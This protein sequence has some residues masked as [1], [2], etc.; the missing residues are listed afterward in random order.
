MWRPQVGAPMLNDPAVLL[1]LNY[2]RKRKL[3]QPVVV[4]L[5]L[6][7]LMFVLH[8]GFSML[9]VVLLGLAAVSVTAFVQFR[10]RV[11]WW[12][13][14]A[15]SVLDGAPPVRVRSQVVGGAGAWTLLSV[16]GGR[17][18]LRVTNTERAV[19][20]FAAR[21]REVSLIGPNADG[22]AAVM[23][24]SLPVPLPAKVVPAPPNPQPV[25]VTD[26]DLSRWAAANTA[27]A[28]YLGLAVVGLC[29]ASVVFDLLL[30]IDGWLPATIGFVFVLVVALV[31]SFFRR[32]D[33][34]RMVKLLRNGPWQ[35]YPVQLL[36]WTGNPALVGRLRLALTLPDG[37]QLPVSARFG[38][39]WLVAN[40][41]ATGTL[42]VAGNPKHGQAAA[43]GL[44]GHPHVAAVRFQELQAR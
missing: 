37:S 36:S 22:V 31:A 27:R 6:A 25:P 7:V 40:I 32:G 34:H 41:A 20:Q 16:D 3:V 4:C 23:L 33:Q 30:T 17:L 9:G 1:H 26:E 42:W 10:S 11:G 5:V 44:P 15:E 21:Q 29:G 18:Y 14:A 38:P 24:D 39:A 43:V 13:P 19:R 35:A 2:W 12:L 28:V 8:R